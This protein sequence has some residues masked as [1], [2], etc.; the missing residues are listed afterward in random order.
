[1]EPARAAPSHRPCRGG[2]DLIQ[3][4]VVPAR[5]LAAPP[6]NFRSASGALLLP[7]PTAKAVQNDGGFFYETAA[8]FYARFGFEPTA[9][10]GKAADA[11]P[12]LSRRDIGN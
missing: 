2:F 8:A 6:A 3:D 5:G 1:M 7:L 10:P 9:A 11:N 4:P 12:A